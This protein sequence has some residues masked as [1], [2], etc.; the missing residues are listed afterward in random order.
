MTTGRF[1]RGAQEAH[2]RRVVFPGARVAL[3]DRRDEGL[4]VAV[5]RESND[6]ALP[7]LVRHDSGDR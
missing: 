5:P 2:G 3:A 4:I 1:F 7:E 6:R